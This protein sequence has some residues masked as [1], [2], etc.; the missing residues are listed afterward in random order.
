[1]GLIYN[2]A[3]GVGLLHLLWQIAAV[4]LNRLSQTL[5]PNSKPSPQALSANWLLQNLEPQA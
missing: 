4:N 2:S 5:N 1:M 3:V